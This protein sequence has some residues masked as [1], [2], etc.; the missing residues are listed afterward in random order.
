METFCVDHIEP[1][2][3]SQDQFVINELQVVLQLDSLASS[4]KISVNV[5]NPDQ[6]NE[7]FDLIS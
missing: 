3:K 5:D 7:I 6:I 2:W 1:T 4:H